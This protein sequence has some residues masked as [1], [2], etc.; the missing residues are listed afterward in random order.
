MSDNMCL[1]GGAVGADVLWGDYASLRGDDVAHFIFRGHRSKA[2]AH[3]LVVLSEDQLELADQYLRRANRTLGRSLGKPGFVRNLLRRN[4]YQVQYTDR[5]YAVSGMDVEGVQGGT[6]WATQMFID[7]HNGLPCECYVFDQ[8]TGE[9]FVWKGE[10]AHIA[11]P[12]SPYGVWTGI[13]SR[14]LKPSGEKA[15][16]VLMTG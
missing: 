7:R 1:S 11:S 9:W 5:V 10:W 13:G 14:V 3:Q 6:A 2:P 8:N 4:W 16:E 15:I 12:P